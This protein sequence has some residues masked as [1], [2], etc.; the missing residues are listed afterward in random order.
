MGD[1]V[2]VAHEYPPIGTAVIV[3]EQLGAITAI[4]ANHEPVFT[5]DDAVLGRPL[6]EGQVVEL[7]IPPS[8]AGA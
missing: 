1:R 6:H 7:P 5:P 4:N 2:E 8:D 3:G